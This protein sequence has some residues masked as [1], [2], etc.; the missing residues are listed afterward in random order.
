MNKFKEEP[1]WVEKFNAYDTS[2]KRGGKR[3][4]KTRVQQEEQKDLST[5]N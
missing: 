3:K 4:K 1:L 5:K 2:I